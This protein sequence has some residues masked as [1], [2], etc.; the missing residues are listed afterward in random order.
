MTDERGD[1]HT[2]QGIGKTLER[3]RA[4]LGLSLWQVEEATKIRARYLRDL[5]RENFGVLP[6]VYVLGSL[7]TYADYLGL[8]GRSMA[9]ELKSRRPLPPEGQDPKPEETTQ[10]ERGGSLAVLGGLPVIGG[11][12]VTEDDEDAAPAA[13]LGYGSRL[14]LGLGVIT[15][16]VLAVVLGPIFGDGGRPAVSQVRE[17]TIFEA[18][19]R[20]AFSGDGQDG[21]DDERDQDANGTDGQ[22]GKQAK[23]PA[24]GNE[25]D[26]KEN[27][28]DQAEREDQ[29]EEDGTHLEDTG[30]VAV[31]PPSS[32][33]ASASASV[34][35]TSIPTASASASS[36]AT[37]SATSTTVA[38]ASSSSAAVVPASTASTAAPS[39]TAPETSEPSGAPRPVDQPKPGTAAPAVGRQV[40]VADRA[41]PVQGSAGRVRVVRSFVRV[42]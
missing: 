42:R 32:T 12:E 23:P 5:E 8:D 22:P 29:D 31:T 2:N 4:Q 40:V 21:R 15:L 37:A 35:A 34:T 10:N 36:A 14:Y 7:K 38:S 25:K 41:Q 24:E 1:S 13:G 11:R 20:I 6:A 33:I 27:E 28:K 3:R 17:P 18:P 26:K 16:L 30:D 39:T 9:R 19:S